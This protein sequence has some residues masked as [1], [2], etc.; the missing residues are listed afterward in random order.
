MSKYL[1]NTKQIKDKIEIIFDDC[2]SDIYNLIGEIDLSDAS[3]E[4]LRYV[5]K[6]RYEI[7]YNIY[8]TIYYRKRI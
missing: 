8:A 3:I 6:K 5:L 1:E 2:F 4:H 7:L